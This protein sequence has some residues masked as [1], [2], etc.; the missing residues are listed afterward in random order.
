[1][2]EL[3][4]FDWLPLLIGIQIGP[5]IRIGGSIGKFGQNLKVGAGK[6]LKTVA[7]AASFIPGVG[8]LAAAGLAAAGTAMDTSKG[9]VGLGD[10]AGAGVKSYGVGRAAGLLS[11][12]PGVGAIG[13]KLSGIPGVGRA[14]QILGGVRD[15]VSDVLPNLPDGMNS[16]NDI[17]GYGRAKQMLT[18][19]GGGEGGGMSVMDKILLG[20]TIAATAEDAMR[21]RGFE[22]RA[23]GHAEGSYNSR[24]PLRGRALAML[25]KDV[26]PDHSGLFADPGN[27]YDTQKRSVAQ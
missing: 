5:R 14:G 17:P 24:A 18:G 7:P 11:K 21:R 26:R 23:I 27:V 2:L 9:R 4:L 25:E 10:I 8:P 3:S 20:G 19:G 1:M 12:I 13:E 6:L 16:I 22:D 15:K